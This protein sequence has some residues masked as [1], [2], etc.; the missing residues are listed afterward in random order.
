MRLRVYAIQTLA[1]GVQG[2]PE[3]VCQK[4]VMKGEAGVRILRYSFASQ[5][6]ASILRLEGGINEVFGLLS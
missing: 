4:A 2:I 1:K 3:H 6:S 5:L